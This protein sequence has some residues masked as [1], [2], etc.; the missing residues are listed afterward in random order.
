MPVKAIFEGRNYSLELKEEAL[1]F[2][3]ANQLSFDVELKFPLDIY[4]DYNEGDFD[5]FFL[6]K[7]NVKENEVRQVC[8]S[9]TNRRVG[10]AIPVLSLVSDLHDYSDNEHFL[11]YAYIALKLSI[12]KL[13]EDIFSKT[14]ELPIDY[15]QL[16][17]IFHD[18]TVL[19]VISKETI[20]EN[21]IFEFEKVTSS[22]VK[23]GY[24]QLTSRTPDDA[25]A[26][27]SDEVLNGKI[28]L[29][30]ASGDIKK[31]S[32]ISQL[33]NRE[34]AFENNNLLRFF[35]VYQ[36]VEVLIE[37]VYLD[38]QDSLVKAIVVDCG[39]VN[40]TKMHL[41]NLNKM[42]SERTRIKKLIN[43]YTRLGGKLNEI[44]SACN[45]LLSK[46]NKDEAEE[47][48]KY[49]YDIRNF[50]FHQYR[51]FPQQLTAEL[52][53]VVDEFLIVLPDFL[54]CY[55]SSRRQGE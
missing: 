15:V 10:W 1:S 8:L 54:E 24:V 21:K 9:K 38:Q 30:E 34:I 41:E 48:H 52:G 16:S 11:K 27:S 55:T 22:L 4:R 29:R 3:L 23:H 45:E 28:N 6:H 51:N 33:L 36:I 14:L 46:L 5:L 32:L 43:D 7:K 12:S 39:D 13:N 40:K 49:F 18:D 17:D 20:G 37:E 53:R 50:I 44:R 2:F 26:I 25:C 31:I 47:F 35:Y 42:M 19:L